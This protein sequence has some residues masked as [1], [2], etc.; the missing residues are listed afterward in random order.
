MDR[1]GAAALF[2]YLPD[3]IRLY[4]TSTVLWRAQWLV[5]LD[6]AMLNRA[7]AALKVGTAI[8]L[9]ASLKGGA[10]G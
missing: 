7:L 4:R 8:E 9:V 5:S 10:D 2:D 3:L 1:V 6:D